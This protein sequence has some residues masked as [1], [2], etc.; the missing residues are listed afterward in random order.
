MRFCEALNKATTC[1]L[2]LTKE[3]V[4]CPGALRSLGWTKYDDET[5]A[6]TMPEETGI[7]HDIALKTTKNTLCLYGGTVAVGIGSNDSPDIVLSYAQPV[8]AM[9][10][11]R[12]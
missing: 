9:R 7:P 10:L 8:V 3:F 5:M 4:D 1:S 11:I 12:R 2:I 6:Q